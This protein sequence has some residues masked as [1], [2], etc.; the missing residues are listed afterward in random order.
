MESIRPNAVRVNR[1]REL[2][3]TLRTRRDRLLVGIDVAKAQHVAQ[4]RLAHT[5]ILDPQLIVPNTR[6]G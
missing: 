2:K 4:V 1:F 3:A 5:R 6:A